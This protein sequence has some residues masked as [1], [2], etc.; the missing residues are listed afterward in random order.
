[1][2]ISRIASAATPAMTSVV[3]SISG[4]SFL[5]RGLLV[6]EPEQ[7]GRQM[8][9]HGL[10]LFDE[11]GADAGR[12]QTALDAAVDEARLLEDEHVLHDDHV[13]FHPLDLGDV[14]DP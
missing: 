3:G 13:A 10:E 11:L 1:K 5:G 14:D 7:A 8:D 2:A 9:A 12:L 4:A 6:R